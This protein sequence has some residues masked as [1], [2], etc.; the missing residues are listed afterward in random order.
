MM[1]NKF[2]FG[3]NMLLFPWMSPNRWSW[4]NWDIHGY[5]L[6]L[7][8]RKK[9]NKTKHCN[10]MVISFL[11]PWCINWMYQRRTWS[12]IDL[13]SLYWSDKELKKEIMYF[14]WRKWA[15][16]HCLRSYEGYLFIARSWQVSGAHDWRQWSISTYLGHGAWHI[17][18][19]QVLLLL[20]VCSIKL[21]TIRLYTDHSGCLIL[22]GIW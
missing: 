17:Q 21:D 13:L 5:T 14:L 8:F 2:F 4:M 22:N 9:Q 10:T 18:I 16:V 15:S 6:Q 20:I 7:I 3:D 11:V 19:C 12:S 1:R